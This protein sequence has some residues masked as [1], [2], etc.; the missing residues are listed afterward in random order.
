MGVLASARHGIGVE[1]G[2]GQRIAFGRIRWLRV[3]AI[4]AVTAAVIV[5]LITIDRFEYAAAGLN[6]GIDYD[7]LMGATRSFLAGNGF[8]PAEQLAGPWIY[9]QGEPAFMP[10][11]LY[12]PDALLLF[13]PLSFLPGAFWWA[14]PIALTAWALWRLR[15]HPAAWLVI[16]L[17]LGVPQSR[18]G[19]FWGNP[20]MWMTALEAAGMVLGW[21]AVLVL[22][23]P[24]LGPFALAG[25][26][27][28]SW[29]LALAA[30]ALVNLPLLPLW[31]D[32]VTVLRNAPSQL[33]LGFSLYQYPLLC[34][35]LVAWLGSRQG[36]IWGRL[37]RRT[38][39]RQGQLVT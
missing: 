34:V 26:W 20:A 23:K 18:E 32:W 27:H 28:R 30:L 25:A 19:I 38:M 4:A 33:S 24:T 1:P 22:L 17:L 8:Y 35:P 6:P 12:P 39:R 9:H 2:E 14:V 21:P 3:W 7:V 29:W 31:V 37:Q 13:V 15:P 16:A 11:I 36:P 5:A 10:P